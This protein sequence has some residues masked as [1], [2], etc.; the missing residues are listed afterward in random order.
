MQRG[1]IY[2]VSL[3]PQTGCEIQAGRPAI[4]VSNNKTNATS[5]VLE[6]VYLTTKP[7]RV[8]PTHVS[9]TST[10]RDSTALCEQISS[11]SRTRFGNYIG[12]CSDEEMQLLDRAIMVSLGIEE[13]DTSTF[14]EAPPQ[15]NGTKPETSTLP[16]IVRVEA[17]RDIYKRMYEQM[18]EKVVSL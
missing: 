10:G 12:Y 1:E 6:V 14:P 16:A 3:A 4:I 13:Q 18:L 17:E 8:F 11:V 7:K 5:D 9:I 2:Y 15:D